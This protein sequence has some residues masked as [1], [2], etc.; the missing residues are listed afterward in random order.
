MEYIRQCS[1]WG[2]SSPE[3]TDYAALNLQSYQQVDHLRT[4]CP[5]SPV[6]AYVLLC[7]AACTIRIRLQL[8]LESG[9]LTAT[10]KVHATKVLRGPT[11][12]YKSS[13]ASWYIWPSLILDEGV[14]LHVWAFC[15]RAHSCNARMV[16]SQHEG[17]HGSMQAY[18]YE[19]THDYPPFLW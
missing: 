16:A 13:S 9:A 10:D 8:C 1:A 12:C 5:S 17:L 14:W 18:A 15:R 11:E 4:C 6:L 3:K 2:T 7:S 19:Q